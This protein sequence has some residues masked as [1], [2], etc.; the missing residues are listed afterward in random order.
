MSK[1]ASIIADALIQSEALKFGEFK[2][3]SGIVSPYYIDLSWLLY[4]REERVEI[5]RTSRE[6]NGRHGEAWRSL[7]I[8]R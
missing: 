2:L 4:N 5:L 6:D 1:K 8:L 3:K 7:L